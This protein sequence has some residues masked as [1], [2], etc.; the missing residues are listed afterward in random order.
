MLFLNPLASAVG[1]LNIS[2][3]SHSHTVY[4]SYVSNKNF[5]FVYVITDNN[6]YTYM[7]VL[8]CVAAGI[9]TGI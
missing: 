9:K 7:F 6:I 5:L 8:R 4:Q 1:T 2:P 3:N